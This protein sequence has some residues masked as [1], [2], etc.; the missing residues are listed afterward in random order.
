MARVLIVERAGRGERLGH[1]LRERGYAVRAIDTDPPLPGRVL[2]AL[3][4]VSVVCWLMALG[5]GLHP[6]VNAAQLE[7]VLLKVVDTGVRG[8]VFE[9]PVD[10]NTPNPYVEHARATW[11]IPIEEVHAGGVSPADDAERDDRA[12]QDGWIAAITAAVDS[13]LGAAR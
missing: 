10:G 8:F 13:T 4:D 2:D 1:A 3:E 5:E 6:E 9:R 11:H 7:A 12:A